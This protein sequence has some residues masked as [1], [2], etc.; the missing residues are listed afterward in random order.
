MT[1]VHLQQDEGVLSATGEL[2][3][4][5]ANRLRQ[6]QDGVGVSRRVG[7]VMRVPSEAPTEFLPG[8]SVIPPFLDLF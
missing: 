1:A 6:E 4:I 3:A 2:S 7:A 8:E 5:G